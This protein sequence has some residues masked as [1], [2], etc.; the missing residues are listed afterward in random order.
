MYLIDEGAVSILKQ[1]E[2]AGFE[3]YLGGGCVRDFLRGTQPHDW[4]ITSSAR[5]EEIRSSG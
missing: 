3:A 1:L 2:E 4:D 5:P